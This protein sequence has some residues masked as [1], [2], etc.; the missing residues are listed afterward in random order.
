MKTGIH[1]WFGYPIAGEERLRLIKETGFDSVFLWWGDETSG[2]EGDKHKLPAMARAAGLE[3]ETVHAPF[4]RTNLIWTDSVDAESIVQRYTQCIL[5]CAQHEIPTVVIHLTN[6]HTP[7]P[8]TQLGID[9]IKYL[10]ELAEQKQ[11]NIALENLKVPEYLDFV[12]SNLDSNRLGFC[13]DSG[14][15]TCYSRGA[16]LLTKYGSKLMALHLH[17]NDGVKDQH[18]IPGEGT[19]NWE[20]VAQKIKSAGYPGPITLELVNEFSAYSQASAQEFLSLAYKKIGLL[21]A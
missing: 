9:R 17:D 10:V 14:H 11:V 3:V 15:E 13:Y 5:D 20:S 8:P 4:E 16:D 1:Y 18:Q 21:F 2:S 19:I 7:P 12:F 6:G